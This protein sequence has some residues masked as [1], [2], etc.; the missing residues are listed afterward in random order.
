MN[1]KERRIKILH[2]TPHLGGGVGRVVLNY[3]TKTKND[4]LF[5]HQLACLD[6]AND[7][8]K[9]ISRNIGIKLA[10]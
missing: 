8:A 7:Y 5:E 3:L 10:M 6:Y 9:I 4:P 2:I 1:M